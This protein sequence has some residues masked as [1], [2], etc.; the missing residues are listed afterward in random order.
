MS[1]QYFPN[2]YICKQ[3][4]KL[5]ECIGMVAATKEGGVALTIL[6]LWK[7]NFINFFFFCFCLISETFQSFTVDESY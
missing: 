7:S 3:F 4:E 1:H 2:F 5:L 6:N